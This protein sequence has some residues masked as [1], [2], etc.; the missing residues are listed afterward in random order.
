[1]FALLLV[2]CVDVIPNQEAPPW[3]TDRAIERLVPSVSTLALPEGE[4]SAVT[5]EGYYADSL[6]PVPITGA[7]WASADE[8]IASMDGGIVMAMSPGRTVVYAMVGGLQSSP[9]SVRVSRGVYELEADTTLVRRGKL[10]DLTV[11]SSDADFTGGEIS[12]SIEGLMPFG[13]ERETDPWW[14]IVPGTTNSYRGVFLA[15]PAAPLGDVVVDFLLDGAPPRDD[16]LI[17]VL[18][19]EALDGEPH[20]CDY[21]EEDAASNWTFSEGTNQA[22]SWLL[23]GLSADTITRFAARSQ[24]SGAVDPWMALWS[25]E[26]ELLMTNDSVPGATTT[27]E[28][29]LELTSLTDDFVGA[30][31]LTV[32]VSPNAAS[33]QAVGT[34]VT[35]CLDRSLP[36]HTAEATSGFPDQGE[37]LLPG[38]NTKTFQFR[39]IGG[40]VSRVY[41][42]VDVNLLLPNVTTVRV[43]A[44]NDSGVDLIDGDWAEDV[45]ST[46]RWLGTLGAP[47]P[48][49][50]TADPR[51]TTQLAGIPVAGSWQL[52][53]QVDGVGELGTWNDAKIWIESR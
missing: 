51:G 31:Y 15:P 1:M 27:D 16:L 52:Q 18:R 24:T 37:T 35:S 33:S 6:E 48:F 23:G 49:I 32:G 22:R 29:A 39:G 5:V 45:G 40:S 50:P 3:S 25:L 53:V 8:A 42:Y 7:T 38:R 47:P 26:G 44:P 36:L 9:I 12:L 2:G 34:L 19:N 11:T 28:A 10:L 46:G 43:I 4:Q 30:W 14:G 41:V 20:D 17:E 21:F 13:D